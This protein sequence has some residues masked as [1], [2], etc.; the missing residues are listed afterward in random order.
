MKA[1]KLTI[2]DIARR[3]RNEDLFGGEDNCIICGRPLSMHKNLRSLHMC[4]D[5][6][7]VDD[8]DNPIQ[9]EDCCEMGYFDVGQ[10]CYNNFKER[11]VEM[12]RE[13][14]IEKCQ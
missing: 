2:Q 8:I 1:L 11:A 7:L 13:E 14:I 10:T 3:Q 9:F 12:T 5:G 4:P 6:T